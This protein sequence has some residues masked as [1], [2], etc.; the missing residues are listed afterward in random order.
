MTMQTSRQLNQGTGL[1]PSSMPINTGVLQRKCAC[2][3]SVQAGGE[4]DEC[5]KKRRTLQRKAAGSQADPAVAPPIVHDV[6]R[7]PGRQLESATRDFMEPRF[8]HDFS[9]VRVNTDMRKQIQ[10]KLTISQPG[11]KYEREADWVADQVMRM[12]ESKLSQSLS[13]DRE[14]LE[15]RTKQRHH[16]RLQSKRVSTRGILSVDHSLPTR[17]QISSARS[18]TKGRK[19]E[20]VRQNEFEEQASPKLDRGFGDRLRIEA[21]EG[22]PL[23]SGTR[24][25][26]EPRFG[27][28]LGHVRIHD[29]PQAAA[30][31][32]EIG[33]R[34]FAHCEH[35][36]F[37]ESHHSTS[38]ESRWLLAHELTHTLQQCALGH[39]VSA[40]TSRMVAAKGHDLSHTP[41][42]RIQ[43]VPWQNVETDGRLESFRDRAGAE[44]RLRQLREANPELEYRIV[45]REGNFIIQSRTREVKRSLKRSLG[46]M[47]R[48][49][50]GWNHLGIGQAP[51][52]G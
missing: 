43:R 35:I 22:R 3:K 40:L 8:G 36:Y 42:L 18:S 20:S 51:K 27:I 49:M 31:S 13:Y 32:R 23:P 46:R 5:R 48:P 26:F 39:D 6:L 29:G 19:W 4:C 9:H 2:G 47:Y 28:N 37:A 50:D 52:P 38:A 41:N 21:S 30:L 14:C 12:P 11:D 1:Q 10:A 45:E 25:F 44:A 33:A 34:A 17:P 15:C 7:S 24:N 16:Q